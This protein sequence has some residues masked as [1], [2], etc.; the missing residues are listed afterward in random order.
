MKLYE[1]TEIDNNDKVSRYFLTC[2]SRRDKRLDRDEIVKVEEVKIPF[3]EIRQKMHEAKINNI[4]VEH[5][6]TCAK[7]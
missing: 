2:K 4:F 7:K 6:I 5:L 3:D 1:I